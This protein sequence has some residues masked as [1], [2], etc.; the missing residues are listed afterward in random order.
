LK[1]TTEQVSLE[2]VARDSRHT[3]PEN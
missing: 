1:A 3:R 2:V